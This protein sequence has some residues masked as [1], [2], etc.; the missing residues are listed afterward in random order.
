ME[1]RRAHLPQKGR[2]RIG[3]GLGIRRQYGSEAVAFDLERQGGRIAGHL[4]L[5]LRAV[6]QIV[7]TRAGDVRHA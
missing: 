5:Q 4:S 3:N 7:V 2:D 6:P 1:R